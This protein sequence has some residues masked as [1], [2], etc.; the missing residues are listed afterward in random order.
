[1][2]QKRVGL[3]RLLHVAQRSLGMDEDAYRQALAVATGKR[4]AAAMSLDELQKAL[5]HFK[6]CGFVVEPARKAGSRPRD[7]SGQG[8]LI[9][10]LW[11]KLHACGAVRDPSEAALA[12][13][14]KR[15]TGVDALQWLDVK[16]ASRCAE[17][18]KKWME[19][20]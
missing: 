4:S 14:V 17:K 19:R 5:D 8:K 11:L 6:R 20:L 2:T 18:L 7:V 3:V 16:E 12:A 15:E 9:R 1:M 10:H 13:W